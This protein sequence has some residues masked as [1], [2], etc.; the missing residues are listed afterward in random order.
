VIDNIESKI[1][2]LRS[3]PKGQAKDDLLTFYSEGAVQFRYFKDAWRNHVAHLREEY[4]RDQARSILTH[5][6]DFMEH[7]AKNLREI[8]IPKLD[9]SQSPATGS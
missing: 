5:T 2:D 3:L 4:D 6:C 1:S 7:L 8:Q 9:V